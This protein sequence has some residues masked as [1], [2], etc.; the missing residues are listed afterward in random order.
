MIRKATAT[1]STSIANIYNHYIAD[2]VITFEESEISL[3][4]MGERIEKISQLGLP[5]L[6]AEDKGDVIGY[7]YASP[8]KERSAYRF[9]VEVTVYL[10]RHLTT[11]GWGTKLYESLFHELEKLPVH[12]AI[13]GITLPN[14]ASVALHEKFGM[15]KV[16]HFQEV[17]YKFEQWL[18]VGYWQVQL[19]EPTT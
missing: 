14:V 17:G 1:D 10:A 4:D 12:S 5:W 3:D 9:S 7:A 18:D 19:H 6:V 8:W 15:E 13:A 16:A 11:K 2:T